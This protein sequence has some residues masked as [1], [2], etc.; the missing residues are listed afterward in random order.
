MMGRKVKN[1]SERVATGAEVADGSLE[2]VRDAA[3]RNVIIAV[4]RGPRPDRQPG[5]ELMAL[6]CLHYIGMPH[7]F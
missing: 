3:G 6:R 4:T 2:N 7:H 1:F 5:G